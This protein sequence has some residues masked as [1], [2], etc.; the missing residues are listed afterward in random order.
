M[1]SLIA[2]SCPAGP[3]EYAYTTAGKDPHRRAQVAALPASIGCCKGVWACLVLLL[4][5]GSCRV[6]RAGGRGRRGAKRRR[7]GAGGALD[8]AAGER[9]M[10]GAGAG[11]PGEGVG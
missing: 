10:T 6:L 2:P 1:S 5:P 9:V 4:V 11:V 3:G 8:A 7:S